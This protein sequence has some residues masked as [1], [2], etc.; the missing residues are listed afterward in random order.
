MKRAAV[1]SVFAF[2]LFASMRSTTDPVPVLGI[3]T[4]IKPSTLDEYMLLRA[5]PST[6]TCRALVRSV[7][8]AAKYDVLASPTLVVVPG[9]RET[10]TQ[11]VKDFDVRFTVALSE[12]KDRAQTE[13]VLTR[14]GEVILRQSSN[15][16]LT[17]SAGLPRRE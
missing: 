16:V 9:K 1:L 14:G 3:E 6:Y 13:V 15:V 10:V 5:T 2:L 12:K 7:P 4:E 17:T 11:K 8:G